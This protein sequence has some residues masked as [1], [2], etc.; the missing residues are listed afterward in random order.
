MP[1]TA[2]FPKSVTQARLEDHDRQFHNVLSL[3]QKAKET[4]AKNI[5]KVYESIGELRFEVEAVESRER[6][7]R[8]LS[9]R[10]RD[11]NEEMDSRLKKLTKAYDDLQTVLN[12]ELDRIRTDHGAQLVKLASENNDKDRTIATVNSRLGDLM[13]DQSSLRSRCEDDVERM[14]GQM[15]QHRVEIDDVRRHVSV[16]SDLQRA[17]TDLNGNQSELASAV[18]GLQQSSIYISEW[19]QTLRGETSELKAIVQRCEQSQMQVSVLHFHDSGLN[20][21]SF[22]LL[23]HYFVI[24][25]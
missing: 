4:G 10:C 7:T 11:E 20:L 8:M 25:M 17:M 18:G 23:A 3:L 14:K 13:T 19:V 24:R 5:D 15:R 12:E 16:V 6:D 9:E 2:P 1:N 21:T 22:S